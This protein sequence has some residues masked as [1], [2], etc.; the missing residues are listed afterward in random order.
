MKTGKR[1]FTKYDSNWQSSLFFPFGLMTRLTNIL[2]ILIGFVIFIDQF[3]AI[4]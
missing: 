3:I 2:D 4:Y 1:T